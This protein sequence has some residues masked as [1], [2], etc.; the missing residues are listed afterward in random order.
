MQFLPLD[1]QVPHR[2]GV[3]YWLHFIEGESEKRR[4][5]YFVIY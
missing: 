3:I 5:D 2:K 1:V 4:A